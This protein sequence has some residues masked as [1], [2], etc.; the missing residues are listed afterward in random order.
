MGR[1]QR[2]CCHMHHIPLTSFNW[3]QM[4]DDVLEGSFCSRWHQHHRARSIQQKHLIENPTKGGRTKVRRSTR[5]IECLLSTRLIFVNDR[6]TVGRNTHVHMQCLVR[7]CSQGGMYAACNTRGALRVLRQ[8]I[9]YIT[10]KVTGYVSFM[11]SSGIE[12]E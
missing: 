2:S 9:P 12:G 5:A 3:H 6:R 11:C 7:G 8:S 4:I 10:D 1:C